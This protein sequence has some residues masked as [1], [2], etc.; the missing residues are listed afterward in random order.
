MYEG[1]ITVQVGDEDFLC[2]AEEKRVC[3]CALQGVS[4]PQS[5]KGLVWFWPAVAVVAAAGGF[6]AS[7]VVN[8]IKQR[9]TGSGTPGAAEAQTGAASA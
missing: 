3:A 1:G 4:K 7:S 5:D 8:A 9:I 6:F 2:R